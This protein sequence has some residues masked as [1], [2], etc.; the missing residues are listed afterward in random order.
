MVDY[1][2]RQVEV[3]R[4]EQASLSLVA[5]LFSNEILNSPLLPRFSL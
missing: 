2:L 1:Q 4:R 5:T 3:Y